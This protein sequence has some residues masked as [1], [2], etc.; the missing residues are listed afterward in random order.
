[1]RHLGNCGNGACECWRWPLATRLAAAGFP[2][3]DVYIAAR[4]EATALDA[5]ERGLDLV[6]VLDGEVWSLPREAD[7]RIPHEVTVARVPSNADLARWP[8]NDLVHISP[9]IES[10]LRVYHITWGDWHP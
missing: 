9:L 10:T 6:A 4:D 5:A 2:Q 1:M 7:G 3:P 8:H